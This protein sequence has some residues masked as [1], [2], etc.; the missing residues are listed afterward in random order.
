[1]AE[2]R[3]TIPVPEP[4]NELA[5]LDDE[6]RNINS[7]EA[8][9]LKERERLNNKLSRLKMV[10][11]QI[12]NTQ[13]K[14]LSGHEPNES[15]INNLIEACNL[16][17]THELISDMPEDASSIKLSQNVVD[18]L[19]ECEAT[20]HDLITAILFV[21][22]LSGG[23]IDLDRIRDLNIDEEEDRR[24][25][26]Q[27]DTFL[28]DKIE[29]AIGLI[30]SRLGKVKNIFLKKRIAQIREAIKNFALMRIAA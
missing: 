7:E 18:S 16:E 11:K 20:D 30:D 4:P 6:L 5:Q 14:I 8:E 27:L 10:K 26:E 17:I 23:D 9:I 28:N 1:M 13:K 29:N 15:A 25:I 12:T 2:D 3:N 21:F 24:K 19:K 22:G